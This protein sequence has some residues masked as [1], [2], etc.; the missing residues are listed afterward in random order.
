MHVDTGP[1]VGDDHTLLFTDCLI[2]NNSGTSDGMHCY[3][4]VLLIPVAPLLCVTVMHVGGGVY[5]YAENKKAVLLFE[6]SE[7]SSNTAREWVLLAAAELTCCWPRYATPFEC[8]LS[9]GTGGA[10]AV[11]WISTQVD[12]VNKS[13]AFQ[14]CSM[15]SNRASETTYLCVYPSFP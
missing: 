3:L 9:A 12:V 1:S 4:P 7:I 10:I 14:N 15:V 2:Y 5:Y 13:V 8:G 6:D 11:S